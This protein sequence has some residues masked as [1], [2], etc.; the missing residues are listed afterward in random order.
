M[1]ARLRQRPGVCQGEVKAEAAAP[2]ANCSICSLP[3]QAFLENG[4]SAPD[5][6][7]KTLALPKPVG[8]TMALVAGVLFGNNFTPPEYLLKT[9]KGEW[10]DAQRLDIHGAPYAR[11]SQLSQHPTPCSTPAPRP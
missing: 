4:D 3:A 11:L 7:P 2:I 9:G 5:D 8:I 6:A 1:H 10:P